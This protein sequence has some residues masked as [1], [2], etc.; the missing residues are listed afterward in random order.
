M[1]RLDVETCH[2]PIIEKPSLNLRKFQQTPREHTPGCLKYTFLEGFP[3]FLE[4]K[5][6]FPSFKKLPLH[7]VH[8]MLN[9]RIFVLSSFQVKS[10]FFLSENCLKRTRFDPFTKPNTEI[11]LDIQ[12]PKLSQKIPTKTSKL[13]RMYDLMSR[14]TL[15]K[16]NSKSLE[17]WMVGSWKIFSAKVASYFRCKKLLASFHGASRLIVTAVVLSALNIS[18]PTTCK[19]I[20]NPRNKHVYKVGAVTSYKWSEIALTNGQK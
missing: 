12:T 3:N 6:T 9:F 20:Q 18:R 16:T 11:T 13:L 2:L 7:G 8:S 17:K 15:P 4:I 1:S 5:G 19:V 14:V 10:D